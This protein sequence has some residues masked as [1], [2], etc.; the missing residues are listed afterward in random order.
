MI[1]A[2]LLLYRII[3]DIMFIIH[4]LK[5]VTLLDLNIYIYI[6]ICATKF[7]VSLNLSTIDFLKKK[8]VSCKSL[9][10]GPNPFI[11][12]KKIMLT[13]S[14]SVKDFFLPF[15]VITLVIDD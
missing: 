12:K 13:T 15:L 6:Y 10:N 8:V 7:I 2:I 14:P 5:Q 3:I 11:F 4:Q 1:R 9:P